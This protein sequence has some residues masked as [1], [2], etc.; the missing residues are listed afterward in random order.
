[1]RVN[2]KKV[3][4]KMCITTKKFPFLLTEKHRFPGY[5]PSVPRSD[6]HVVA[7]AVCNTA[8]VVA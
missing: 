4:N 3:K 6:A 1:M 5:G 8:V 2:K 7:V